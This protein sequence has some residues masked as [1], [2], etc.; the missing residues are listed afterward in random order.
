MRLFPTLLTRPERG[1][2]HPHLE[3]IEPRSDNGSH[4]SCTSGCRFTATA[5][6]RGTVLRQH[7]L[8]ARG[9]EGRMS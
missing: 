2:L 6:K 3:S 9:G 5:P 7:N 1:E 4:G 8:S